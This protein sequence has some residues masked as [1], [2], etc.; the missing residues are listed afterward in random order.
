MSKPTL[1]ERID[2]LTAAVATL[3]AAQAS[4][5][6]PS[7]ATPA[8]APERSKDGRDFPCT[9]ASPCSRSLRSAKRAAV[10]GV[11]A[12]GHDPR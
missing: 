1:T 2:A 10:H 9:A 11:D 5:V 3:V 6:A 12:G 7:V 8:I 4:T